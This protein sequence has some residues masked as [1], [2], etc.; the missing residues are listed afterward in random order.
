MSLPRN[1]RWQLLSSAAGQ[2]A[3]M[4][5]AGL[6][7]HCLNAWPHPAVTVP[8]DDALTVMRTVGLLA[9]GERDLAGPDELLGLALWWA[10]T[11]G[12]SREQRDS[13]SDIAHR[14]AQRACAPFTPVALA[15][16]R[17][18][19]E[20]LEEHGDHAQAAQLWGRLIALSQLAHQTELEQHARLAHAVGLHRIG[21]CGEALNQI[22]YAWQLRVSRPGCE[23]PTTVMVLRLHLAMLTACGQNSDRAA[24]LAEAETLPS[25]RSGAPG[26]DFWTGGTVE[27]PSGHEPVCA[28][29]AYAEREGQS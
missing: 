8:G 5:T 24:L 4:V 26:E 28:F 18:R 6:R 21:Q 16:A 14:I 23:Q 17:L 22:G 11:P 25:L 27:T 12:V 29:R 7:R 2:Q 13:L 3:E 20:V 19:A 15:A 10:A 1:S 9:T